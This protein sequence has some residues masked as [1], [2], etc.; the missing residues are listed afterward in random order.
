MAMPVQ[1]LSVYANPYAAL[2]HHDRPCGAFQHD[3][4]IP[5]MAGR[6]VGA[7]MVAIETQPEVKRVI[8]NSTE[9]LNHAQ[10]DRTWEFS[11]EPVK[12]ANNLHYVRGVKDG[13]LIAADESTA[14][15]CGVALVPFATAIAAAKAAVGLVE[16]TK[17]SKPAKGDK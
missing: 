3:V 7:T 4:S 11:S 17:N 10:H 9:V 12:V 8:G 15:A 16:E 1:T 6:Y 5:G 14:K 13:V 2:D